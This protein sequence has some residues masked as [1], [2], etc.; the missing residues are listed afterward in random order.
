[1]TGTGQGFQM[2]SIPTFLI[3]LKNAINQS[4]LNYHMS[5]KKHQAIL[6]SFVDLKYNAWFTLGSEYKTMVYD[7]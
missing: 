2:T 5:I 7:T 6:K 4:Y 1:M 3:N